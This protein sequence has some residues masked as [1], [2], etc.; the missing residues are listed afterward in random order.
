MAWYERRYPQRG[1]RFGR[2]VEA[3]LERIVTAPAS[4]AVVHAPARSAP[5]Q[6]FPYRV[7][8]VVHGDRIFILAIAHVRR[9]PAYWRRR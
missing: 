2:A 3:T 9:S 1:E 4:F 8:Y 6:R 7:V 5:V